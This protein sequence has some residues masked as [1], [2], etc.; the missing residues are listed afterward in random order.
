MYSPKID[1][2]HIPALYEL[3]QKT[4]R[5]MTRLVNEAIVQYLEKRAEIILPLTY[6]EGDNHE[7]D[8]HYYRNS[9]IGSAH[10]G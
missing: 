9:H 3:K 10:C 5:P 6:I 8:S 7:L 1:E 2:K 4:K